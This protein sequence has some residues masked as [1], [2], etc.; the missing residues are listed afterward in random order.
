MREQML[1]S[2]KVS[3]AYEDY[4]CSCLVVGYVLVPFGKQPYNKL[5]L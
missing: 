1:L 2:F 4:M 3:C 5:S